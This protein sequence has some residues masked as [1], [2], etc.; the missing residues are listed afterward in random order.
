M[1]ELSY[2]GFRSRLYPTRGK[3][4]IYST[5]SGISK[6]FYPRDSWKKEFFPERTTASEKW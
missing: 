6:L 3:D 5:N 4:Q 1:C 2:S